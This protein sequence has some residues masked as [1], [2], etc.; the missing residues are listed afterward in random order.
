MKIIRE[1]KDITD[2]PAQHF[3][4]VNNCG[5]RRDIKQEFTILRSRGRKDH[6]LLYIQEGYVTVESG[7]K[8]VKLDAGKCLYYPPCV[9]HLYTFSPIGNPVAWYVHFTGCAAYES[10]ALLEPHD[11]MIY[12]I[13]NRTIFEG[14]FHRLQ[15]TYNTNR[16]YGVEKAPMSFPEINGILLELIDVLIR[17]GNAKEPWNSS[18]IMIA[19]AYIREH[20]HEEV[21][22]KDCAANAH[23]SMSRFTHL[24]SEKMGISPRRFILSLRI[25]A[26]KELLLY[27]SLNVNEVSENVGFSDPSYF[28]RIFRKYAGVS[29]SIYRSREIGSKSELRCGTYLQNSRISSV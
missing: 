12:Q 24:F 28:S 7:D 11:D 23:L 3:L 27:S 10:M 8:T 13:A 22:L 18:E 20:F 9:R 5:V 6:Y 16:I 21:D 14:L 25:D 15:Y 2:F 19:A 29:P 1:Y 26:A 17:S 4:Q